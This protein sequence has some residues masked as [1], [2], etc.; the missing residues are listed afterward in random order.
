VK[1]VP[2]LMD[3]IA[4]VERA[5]SID[6]VNSGSASLWRGEIGRPAEV[7][8]VVTADGIDFRYCTV[9]WRT[10]HDPASTSRSFVLV[11]PANLPAAQSAGEQL[12]HHLAEAT[13][14]VGRGQY[15]ICQYC[16]QLIPPERMHN[17]ETCQDC[18]SARG[19]AAF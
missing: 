16:H 14:I 19:G 17:P 8:I 9:E 18:A 15:Q 12:V 3:M 2:G 10:P 13:R 6:R 4:L 5:L 11:S 7:V 1:Y